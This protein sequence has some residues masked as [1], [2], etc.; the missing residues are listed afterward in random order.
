MVDGNNENFILRRVWI[1]MTLNP[2]SWIAGTPSASS[3]ASLITPHSFKELKEMSYR[4]LEL[5]EEDCKELS[6]CVMPFRAIMSDLKK[7]DESTA[8]A[9]LNYLVKIIGNHAPESTQ[10]QLNLSKNGRSQ[11]IM[12]IQGY[13]SFCGLCALNNAIGGSQPLFSTIDLDLAVDIMWLRQVTEIGCGLSLLPEPMR[14]LDGDY[15]IMAMEK[16]AMLKNIGFVRLD[17]LQTGLLHANSFFV[18][19]L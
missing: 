6:E 15:S 2:S 16:A 19:H 17:A 12:Q 9:V 8:S 11:D 4:K 7:T 3:T 18:S 14:C 1:S 13:S 10:S 5:I